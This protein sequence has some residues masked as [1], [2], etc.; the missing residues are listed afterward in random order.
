MNE[1]DEQLTLDDIEPEYELTWDEWVR[2]LPP[3]SSDRDEP[4]ERKAA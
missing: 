2:S 3:M 4:A 1:S